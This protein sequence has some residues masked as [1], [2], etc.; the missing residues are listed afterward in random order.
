MPLSR[1]SFRVLPTLLL[2]ASLAYTQKTGE[3]ARRGP[4]QTALRDFDIRHIRTPPAE[5]TESKASERA[6]ASR[7]HRSWIVANFGAGARSTVDGYGRLRVLANDR[8]PLTPT[9]GRPPEA[10]AR[11]LLDELSFGLGLTGIA[12]G[13]F[14]AESSTPARPGAPAYLTFRQTF[15]GIPVFEGRADFTLDA[16]GRVVMVNMGDLLTRA[17]P[18]ETA[19]LNE[20]EAIGKAI[21]ALGMELASPLRRSSGE[22]RNGFENPFSAGNA[23]ITPELWLF[24][25]EP[26]EGRLA[27]RL[28]LEVDGNSYYEMV[29]D[30]IDGRLLYR[31]NL[32]RDAGKGRVWVESPLKGARELVDFPDGW[33][34]TGVQ[35]TKGNN[36]DAYLDA[37]GDNNPDASTAPNMVQ[38]HASSATQTFDFPADEGSAS[39]DP[40]NTPAASVVSL[41]YHVNKA[42]DYFYGLGFD[43]TSWNF[44]ASNAGKG[45]AGNDAVVAEAQDGRT[46]NNANM[47][48]PPDGRA[49]RLQAGLFTMGTTSQTDDRDS[50]YEGQVIFHEYGHGVTNR[51]VG[52]GTETGCLTGTQSGAMGEGWSDYFSST[53]FNNPVQGAY[54]TR[55]TQH[56]IRRFSYAQHPLT[57]ADLGNG[58]SGYKVHDDGEIWAVALW[59]LRAALG[60]KVTDQLVLSAL[61]STPCKPSM[62][63]ARDAILAADLALNQGANRK[64]IWQVFAKR[65]MGASACG[66]D[67][68]IFSG[69][70]HYAAFDLPAD[71]EGGSSPSP[72]SCPALP[73]GAGAIGATYR[74]QIR[75]AESALGQLEYQVTAGPSGL[76]VDQNG[77]ITWIPGLVGARFTV[78]I[79]NAQGQKSV[80]GGWIP[81]DTPLVAGVPVT[82]SAKRGQT[83]FANVRVPEGTTLLQVTLRGGGDADLVLWDPDGRFAGESSANAN[84]N[85]N[86]SV[87]KPKAGVW[88]LDINAFRDFSGVTLKADLRDPVFLP[89]TTTLSALAEETRSETYY[90]ITVPKGAQSLTIRT[91]GGT[92][93]VDLYLR[94]GQPAVCRYVPVVTQTGTWLSTNCNPHEFHSWEI[95]NMERINVPNPRE[96]DWY[97]TLQGWAKF[98]GVK[99]TTATQVTPT[100]I[101]SASR[102]AYT[103]LEESSVPPSQSLVITEAGGRSFTWTAIAETAPQTNWLKLTSDGKALLT[104]A[105]VTTGL[106]PGIHQGKVTVT[107]TGLA[108]SPLVV[109][110]TLTLLA[111]PKVS[112]AP[113]QLSFRGFPGA[114]PAVQAIEVK[115]AGGGNLSWTVK[116]ETGGGGNWLLV[117]PAAGLGE[118]RITVTV[119]SSA[120][121]PGRYTGNVTISAVDALVPA[122]IPVTLEQA[123]PVSLQR[124]RNSA[125]PA[126]SDLIAPGTRLVLTGLNFHPACSTASDSGN[127]CPSASGVPLPTQ[128]GPTR[129]T[130]NGEPGELRLVTPTSIDVASPLTLTGSQVTIIVTNGQFSSNPLTV[131]LAEQALGM[132]SA[133]GTLGGAGFIRHGDRQ[134]I[135]RARPLEAGEVIDLMVTGA[136]RVDENRI[137]LIPLRV[138]FDGVDGE[139][140]STRVSEFEGG[141]YRVEVKVPDRL[142]RRFPVVRV[143]SGVSSSD[144][145]VYTAGGPTITAISLSRASA[146]ADAEVTLRGYNFAD[147]SVVRVGDMILPATF[148]DAAPQTLTTLLP[149]SFLAQPGTV[150]LRVVDRDLPDEV[151]SNPATITVRAQ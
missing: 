1:N 103:A 121:S 58:A 11:G 85:E 29:V 90:R 149:A 78:A 144:P 42:H 61:K 117:Q 106:A 126:W 109:P 6:A 38:G 99:L 47:A 52:R 32:Y 120:L 92:G 141:I 150:E 75:V 53:F 143:Y 36:V 17:P 131:R 130:F 34:A 145:A 10:T 63:Q 135:T 86:V 77:L 128:L 82:I 140:Y 49:P 101:L 96:G 115:N 7:D 83:G 71:M 123:V 70:V 119:R 65:G 137:T 138:T 68:N 27:W 95:G 146:D 93:D 60:A 21:A 48:T 124:F 26:A 127:P 67:G 134:F 110:V 80:Y 3:E 51:L 41:F 72:V 22:E 43:E 45:G 9:A 102:L 89:A 107:A 125:N 79:T 98:S 46:A 147:T 105:V 136:G 8:A 74:H 84:S 24:T 50:A 104:V 33:L 132:F 28:F 148:T 113:G 4:E 114:D 81:V 62:I 13:N 23:A 44:Q 69:N 116:A 30:A 35:I 19:R 25:L 76:E 20:E 16:Q 151:P 55:N 40:R 37:N 18:I 2:A 57:F 5:S 112:A 100:L 139:V 88:L 129:V 15:A 64:A 14:V 54:L 39:K 94:H 31:R 97:L 122:I 66:L 142:W 108:G 91:E 59:D 133:Y 73:L 12:S 111:R 87:S 56:G 118:G